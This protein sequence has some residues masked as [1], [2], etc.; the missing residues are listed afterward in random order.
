MFKGIFVSAALMA[1]VSVM[2]AGRLPEAVRF[3]S[4]G[5]FAIGPV[6]VFLQHFGPDWKGST[7]EQLKPDAGFPKRA[8]GSFELRGKLPAGGSDAV[9]DATET[10]TAAGDD[11]F[12]AAY[13]LK[14]GDPAPTNSLALAIDIPAGNPAVGLYVGGGEVALP[15]TPGGVGMLDTAAD[16]VLIV[17]PERQI[18]VTGDFQVVVQDNRSFQ[19]DTF[20]I[21]LMPKGV[22]GPVADWALAADF[23]LL[24]PSPGGRFPAG[25]G[26]DDFGNL[27][28]G[29]Y[30]LRWTCYSP[31][32]RGALLDKSAFKAAA[33]FPRRG[34]GSFENSGEWNG[35]SMTVTAAAGKNGAVAYSAGF[36]ADPPVETATLAMVMELPADQPHSI[37]AD[38]KKIDLPAEFKEIRIFGGKVRSF[39]I[40]SAGRTVNLEGDFT[41]LVQD[42]RKW[43]PNHFLIRIAANPSAGKISEAA[44]DLSLRVES[45]H[46]APVD[47]KG[48][49]NMGFR[50]DK[51]D[52]GK[53]GWSDQG[54]TND[55]RMLKPGKLSALG[56]D[57]DIV[58]PERNDGRSCLV[59]SSRQ[60]K[61]PAAKTVDVAASGEPCRY[62]YLLH[63][64]AWTPSGGKPVGTVVAE[65]A[66]GS[67]KEFPVL[68]GRDV[69]NWWQPF[70]FDNGAIAWT[71]ENAESFVGLYLSQFRVGDTPKKLSF[72]AAEG[73]NAVW[74]IVGATLGDRQMDFRQIETPS[75]IV[76][77]KDWIP[78]E[79][80]GKTVAGSPLDFSAF[81][82]APAGK[83]G[84]VTV[85]AAGRFSFRDAPEKRIRFF[86]PNL[87][88]T[89]NYLDKALADDFVEK[90]VRL[91]YNTIRFHH[92]E[93][94][95]VASGAP[96]SL[97]LDPGALDR[98]DYLFAELK[99]H[100]VYLCLDLYASRTLR[101]GDGIEE[102]EGR[103]FEH[104]GF[105][106]KSLVPISRTAM[107]NW[108]G[109]ARR[110]LTHRNPYTGLTWGEDP[111]LY[112]VNLVNENP[113]LAIWNRNPSL[114]PLY[115]AKYAEYLKA[116][117]LD[118][119]ENRESRGGLFIE[120]L[121]DLQIRSIEEQKRFLKDELKLT[122]LVTDL[123]MVSKYTLDPVREHLEF[124]D[125]HQYWDH[126][127]FP[128]QQW[129]MPYLFSNNSSIGRNAQNPRY[130]MPAR[131]FG[132]PYTVTEFNFCNPNPFRVEGAP[133]VGGYAALQ[134]WDGLYRFAWSHSRDNMT[135][136]NSPKGFDI[137]NDPQAQL[138]ER[139]IN[140]L[141]LRESVP[142]AKP[143]FAFTYTPE[144]IRAIAGSADNSGEYPAEFT[145][146]G[147]Y[148]RIGT[149]GP[150]AEFPGV[151]KVDALND[152]WREELPAAARAALAGLAEKGT[153]ASAGGEITLDAKAKS[154][155]IVAPKA[156]VM[157]FSGAESGRVMR[158]SGGS[159]YQTVALLSLDGK[160]LAESG[161]ILLFQLA[162]LA[163][164]MQKF[165]SDRRNLLESWGQLPILLEKCR[166]DVELTLPEMKVEALKLDGSVNGTVP[167]KYEGGKLRFTADT[168]SRPGGVMVYLL[169]R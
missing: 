52:D 22:V 25:L 133:L 34:P 150:R 137:V 10:V 18:A 38:G 157:T 2:A 119:P 146:L 152:G 132:K 37:S 20:T 125:N 21:R 127:G 95:I 114:I 120:F 8:D 63:A 91:G 168:A 89:S 78:L 129:Q 140:L 160:P 43:N 85:N 145:E 42:D 81:L 115:E 47:L 147:L 15:E 67:A 84:P 35:F 74:M 64:S 156:E 139:I 71:G 6:Q 31:D 101:P 58:N 17:L 32:W 77:D 86:G 29:N 27:L 163:G 49:F 135:A 66:D 4:Q 45:P 106:M 148:A 33:G 23:R 162:N 14:A 117:G 131:I 3:D 79:Y 19:M 93:N 144:Q 92:F 165:S 72:K 103:S 158:L 40:E 90:A 60:K 122:A 118:T 149:L 59:L 164:T 111:A 80:D 123:N 28:F 16:R 68:S 112:S 97:T 1:A 62:L 94:G 100:G 151:V 116:K 83:Y 75:Y 41:L 87:V 11:A 155:K 51:A 142:A 7:Q 5:R 53:G 48:A 141:F 128:V 61:F 138:G 113:L 136:V 98:L 13:A 169:T 154:L 134:D 109:F 105:E 12:R 46:T 26:M 30:A 96:D 167:A 65:Y 104:Y 76:A 70:G 121:N 82:D 153:I 9:F 102:R 39:R 159:R 126:P 130:L 108:K 54:A 124:V 73:S 50:D 55:L 161:K 56:V 99:K 166:V 24:P 69:G 57:F 36:K 44:L 88:G 107:E 143:A 110:L